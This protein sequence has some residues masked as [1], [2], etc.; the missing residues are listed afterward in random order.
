MFNNKKEINKI[1]LLLQM[2]KWKTTLG[3]NM[4]E[5]KTI[6]YLLYFTIYKFFLTIPTD[7]LKLVCFFR[8]YENIVIFTTKKL[9]GK[10]KKMFK[11]I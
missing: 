2:P 3:K 4:S 10:M 1:F 5:G 7:V 6:T 9:I 11:N 8:I